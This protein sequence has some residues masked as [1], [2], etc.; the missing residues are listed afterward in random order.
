MS[1]ADESLIPFPIWIPFA[2]FS[3]Q[4]A[5]VGISKTMLNKSGEG[6]H[7]CLVSYLRGNTFSFSPLSM[8]LVVGLLL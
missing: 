4:I 6:G 8:L 2:S 3:S 5:V 1:S 7:P